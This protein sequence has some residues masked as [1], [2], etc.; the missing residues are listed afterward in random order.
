MYQYGVGGNDVPLDASE[1]ITNLAQNR[2]LF[3]QQ[4]TQDAPVKPQAVYDLKTI[5]EVFQ[6]FKPQVDV[7]FETEDGSTR[8]E[9]L[10]FSNLGDFSTSSISAQSPYLQDLSVQQ[11]QYQKMIKQLDKNKLMKLVMANPEAKN[12]FMSAL[13]SLLQELEENK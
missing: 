12:A 4:L 8:S 9:T 7:D 11:D 3:V 6:H 13:Q 1:A 10:R 5:E 2:T